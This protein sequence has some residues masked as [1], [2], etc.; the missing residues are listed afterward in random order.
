MPPAPPEAAPVLTVSDPL[1][2]AVAEPVSTFT[3]PVVAVPLVDEMVKDVAPLWV[4]AAAALLIV[5]SSATTTAPAV[6]TLNELP[7]ANGP[8]ETVTPAPPVFIFNA[9]VAESVKEPDVALRLAACPSPD[10]VV[11]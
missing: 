2:P 9:D 11:G 6:D 4:I 5:M 8:P 3:L 7:T 10:H 1:T